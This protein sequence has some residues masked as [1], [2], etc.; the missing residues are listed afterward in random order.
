MAK[1]GGGPIS[2]TTA[3]LSGQT[4]HGK[5]KECYLQHHFSALYAL[6]QGEIR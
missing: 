4:P 2:Y 5:E 3:L 6:Q 1:G